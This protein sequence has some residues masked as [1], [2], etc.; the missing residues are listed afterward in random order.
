MKGES[1]KLEEIAGSREK[2][3]DDREDRSDKAEGE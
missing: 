2:T 1:I 3:K